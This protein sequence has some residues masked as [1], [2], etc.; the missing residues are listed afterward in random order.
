MKQHMPDRSPRPAEPE[1]SPDYAAELARLSRDRPKG[2]RTSARIR[3]AACVL[4]QRHAPQDVTIPALCK[5]AGIAHGTFY[6][7]FSDR[8]LLLADTL[9]GFVAFLQETMRRASARRPEDTIRASTT[10]Y[11]EMFEQN[12]GLMNCLLH[13]H[14][15]FPQARAAFHRLNSEWI[16]TVVASV[17]TRLQRDGRA[18]TITREELLRRGHALGGM[19]DQYLSGLIL[20]ADPTLTA[21]STRRDAVIDTLCLIWARGMEP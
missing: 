11:A 9:L 6:L 1:F 2:E 15:S 20:S 21:L 5:E 8:N 17:R 4:L 16:E 19:V 14:D 10:A 7:Y 18:E 3:I 13:H 12:A